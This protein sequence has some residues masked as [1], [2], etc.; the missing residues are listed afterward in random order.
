MSR[1]CSSMKASTLSKCASVLVV[2]IFVCFAFE[3]IEVTKKI[4]PEVGMV[5]NSR[6]NTPAPGW[7]GKLLG[8]KVSDQ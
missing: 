4:F 6:C 7:N 2:L 1:L 8:Y 5:L 3:T